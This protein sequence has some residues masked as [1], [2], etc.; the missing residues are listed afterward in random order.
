[1]FRNFTLSIA[2][3]LF[4]FTICFAQPG[5]I[6]LRGKILDGSTAEPLSYATISL[7]AKGI[8]TMTNENGGFVF[9]VPV[10]YKAESIFVSHIGYEPAVLAVEGNDNRAMLIR[11]EKKINQLQEVTVKPPNAME[12]LKK[13]IEK[14]PE[15][16]PSSPYLLNGFYRLTG[17]KEKD[18]VHMSEAVFDIYNENYS[19]RNK[20]VKLLKARYDKDLTAFKGNDEFDF[21]STPREILDYDIVS[22]VNESDIL[23]KQEL[24]NYQFSYKG[25]IDY[26]G[27]EAYQISFDQKDGVK[28]SLKQGIMIIDAQN[29]AFLEFRY[30]LS[31]K[32]LKYWSIGFTKKMIL[33][34]SRIRIDL[35]QDSNLVT[36]KRYGTKYYLNHV[37]GSSQWHIVGGRDR[38]ELNPF[39][40]KNNYLVTSID[41]TAAEPFKNTEVLASSRFMENTTNTNYEETHDPFWDQYNLIQADFN[42]DSVARIINRN[43]Q[44]LNYKDQLEKN[45]S[46]YSRDP[47]IR[48]DSILS[49]YHRLNQFNGNALITLGGKTIYKKSF[50]FANREKNIPNSEQTRFRIGSASKQFTAMLIVQLA[51]EKRIDL[52]D[53]IGK[54]IPGYAHGEVTIGQLMTHQSGI[55][56]YTG[57][58]DYVAKTVVKKY[59]LKELVT[60]FCSDPLEF[61]PGTEFHYSNS[62]YLILALIIEKITGKTYAEVL[63]EKIFKPTGMKNSF[64]GSDSA[65]AA[66]DLATG[67]VNGEPELPYAVENITGAGG[68]S[69][70]IEDLLRWNEALSSA[71]L[72]PHEEMEQIFK[73][74][75]EWKEWGAGYG[76]GWMLDRFQFRVSKKHTIQYHPGTETG[77]YSMLVRQPDK[78]IVIILLNN[79]GEFPRFDM[80][81]LILELLN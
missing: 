68:I 40:L 20:Q 75:V 64:F 22:N 35:L 79:T 11:L 6:I 36:Y 28:R 7:S 54:F 53:S 12:L 5:I 4:Y 47:Q 24:K 74:R 73:P 69:S 65:A 42:V 18:I 29:F 48:I 3:S 70:T 16:Y 67:Y 44:T 38:F 81:D 72:V 21:G 56:N 32:G 23:S 30:R 51:K 60:Q 2:L 76:Y 9:K 71:S 57:N 78:G 13:A 62:G 31:P 59:P 26:N 34:L 1:M 39:R 45:L 37:Q 17:R 25:L 63:D 66:N 27:T 80:T 19:R 10:Q 41:T 77:F 61:T 15:N 14:I 43:N 49:F 33:S 50:G 58:Q 52:G 8:N 55:P 46:K